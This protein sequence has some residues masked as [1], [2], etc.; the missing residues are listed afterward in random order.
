MHFKQT[1][2]HRDFKQASRIYWK[3]LT[4]PTSNDFEV[5]V[6]YARDHGNFNNHCHDDFFE[7][8]LVTRGKAINHLEGNNYLIEEGSIFVVHPEQKHGYD[9]SDDLD[10]FNICIRESALK[11]LPLRLLSSPGYVAFFRVEPT[12]RHKKGLQSQL[13]LPYE[14]LKYAA[15]LVDR[16]REVQ[17]NPEPLNEVRAK[18]IFTELLAK[19]SLE[20]QTLTHLPVKQVSLQFA[21]VI[22][23][24]EEHF[25]DQISVEDVAAKVGM[26]ARTL[27]RNC[28]D[29]A[30]IPPKQLLT[31]LRINQAKQWLIENNDTITEI[32]FATGFTDS[33]HFSKQF[34]MKVGCTPKE[35]RLQN[36]NSIPLIAP[37]R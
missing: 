11:Q 28:I 21:K 27:H 18:A 26:S 16:L 13:V 25:S 34:K 37:S 23:F 20:Y 17:A 22:S 19:I 6:G 15:H 10:L 30:G 7:M 4:Y 14:S 24:I 36:R 9:E 2:E 8:V 32:A 5:Q 3:D 35:F 33:N 12:F 31:N 29:Y 1:S